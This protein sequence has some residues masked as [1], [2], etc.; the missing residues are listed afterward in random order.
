MQVLLS[1]WW[2]GELTDTVG[3]HDTV[4][5]SAPHQLGVWIGRFSL[6]QRAKSNCFLAM[7]TA[8]R[9]QYIRSWQCITA[10]E[11]IERSKS[12]PLATVLACTA[13]E[14]WTWVWA[15]GCGEAITGGPLPCIC[16][17]GMMYC[18]GACCIWAG[19][20]RGAGGRLAAGRIPAGPITPG[21]G[22]PGYPWDTDQSPQTSLSFVMISRENP[23]NGKL[24]LDIKSAAWV[25]SWSAVWCGQSSVQRL[26]I[27]YEDRF[28]AMV[29]WL[30]MVCEFCTWPGCPIWGMPCLGAP[31][32]CWG[33]TPWG[34]P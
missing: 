9:E 27:M 5:L 18:W 2:N 20:I 31:G 12:L 4:Q 19:A 21:P 15:W 30:A 13:G 17:W 23:R 26:V 25:G 8:A 34:G 1:A 3:V 6:T 11:S 28:R 14:V 33:P 32:Y 10:K 22:I 24:H 29:P 7:L 16:C